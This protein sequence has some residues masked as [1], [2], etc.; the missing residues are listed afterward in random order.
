MGSQRLPGKVLKQVGHQPLLG[1][2][3]GQ[4]KR[5]KAADELVIATS[6]DAVDEAIVS[7]C[8][9]LDIPCYRGP[10]E[11]VL[12]RYVEAAHVYQADTVVRICADCPLIDPAVVDAVIAFYNSHRS[13]YDYVSN[14]LQRTFPRGQDVEVFSR[15]AL[16]RI[17]REAKQAEE[18]EHV[19]PY[20]YRHPELFRLGNVFHFQDLSNHRWVV[21]TQEDFIFISKILEALYPQR[22]EYGMQDVLRVLESHPDW[23]KINAHIQQKK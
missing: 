9:T 5:V 10:L 22:P 7:L 14:C 17:G 21:D 6:T 8:K 2:V 20:F 18:R 11:D 13:E 12:G 15:Q 23:I 1:Y 4:L 19:T 3:I 16:D